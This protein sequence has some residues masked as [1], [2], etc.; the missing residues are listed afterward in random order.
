MGGRRARRRTAVSA[1]AVMQ[2][3]PAGCVICRDYSTTVAIG[4]KTSETQLFLKVHPTTGKR[5]MLQF[6][7]GR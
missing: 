1:R 6:L 7:W 5:V 4:G 2:P 3:M